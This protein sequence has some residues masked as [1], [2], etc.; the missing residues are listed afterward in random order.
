[1][2]E[3]SRCCSQV[4]GKHACAVVASNSDNAL[5]LLRVVAAVQGLEE[6]TQCELT[7]GAAAKNQ[8]PLEVA[9]RCLRVLACAC[10]LVWCA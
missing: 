2:W 6:G 4:A 1:M 7:P 5:L 10:V 9:L 3:V 8:Q